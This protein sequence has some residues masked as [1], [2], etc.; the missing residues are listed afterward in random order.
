M[1]YQSAA[2]GTL[3]S[4]YPTLRTFKIKFGDLPPSEAPLIFGNKT[5][6][7]S[8][9]DDSVI[10]GIQDCPSMGITSARTYCFAYTRNDSEK[11]FCTADS[12]RKDEMDF[13]IDHT[14]VLRAAQ[15]TGEGC[16]ASVSSAPYSDY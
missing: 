13:Y 14:G 11:W 3:R 2:V 16:Q 12:Y 1:T 10:E 8:A 7:F 9:S 5:A 6:L 4:I 15:S